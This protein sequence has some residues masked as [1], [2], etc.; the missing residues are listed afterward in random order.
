MTSTGASLRNV[1]KNSVSR[2]P[3]DVSRTTSPLRRATPATSRTALKR[4]PP[5][6]GSTRTV[7]SLIAEP[8]SAHIVG[9]QLP[10][11]V[12]EVLSPAPRRELL[13]QLD[14]SMAHRDAVFEVGVRDPAHGLGQLLRSVRSD[15]PP[16][17]TV[18][19]ETRGCAARAG[20]DDRLARR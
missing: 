15:D 13:G 20:A 4:C 7:V 2:A 16:V 19:N 6:S 17:V 18:E 12:D 10:A 8:S 14:A 1:R 5:G 3:T 9:P 11:P